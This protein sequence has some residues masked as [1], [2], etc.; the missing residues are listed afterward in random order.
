MFTTLDICIDKS[1]AGVRLDAFLGNQGIAD[2]PSRSSAVRHIEE[3]NVLIDGNT[4]AKNYTLKIGN[5]IHIEV[6]SRSGFH[7]DILP[8]NNIF[9]DIRFEDDD[10]IVLSKQAGLVCHPSKGHYNDTLVNAL[11]AHCGKDKL[12]CAQGADRPGIVHRLDKDTSGLMLAAKTDK[13]A[14]KLQHD[15]GLH[16]TD[17]RYIALVHGL[18]APD[19]GMI[20]A[21]I[22][23]DP[24]NRL[25]MAISDN[26]K[27]RPSVTTFR[28]LQ[29]FESSNACDAYTLIECKLYTGRTHQI[30][31]HM[32]YVNHP[33]VGDILY[34][35]AACAKQKNKEKALKSE[36]GLDRQFLHSYYLNFTHPTLGKTMTFHDKLPLVLEEKLATLPC[37]SIMRTDFYNMV[38]DN[39][40]D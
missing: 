16:N 36:L 4:V 25:R 12:A 29:R 5:V 3:G 2:I 6:P 7:Q 32:A 40:K 28:V 20:D 8:N 1:Q 30:R 10:I 11:V 37:H 22:I 13:A 24:S 23:R 39:L 26:L 19:T 27:A 34:G 33:V 9:L 17:R 38:F 35:K 15:I 21:P 31:V 18:I 14:A